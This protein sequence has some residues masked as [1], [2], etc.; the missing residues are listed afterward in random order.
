MTALLFACLLGAAHADILPPAPMG[1]VSED[2]GPPR[3]PPYPFPYLPIGAAVAFLL[4]AGA[5]WRIRNVDPT[6]DA[7]EAAAD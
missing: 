7:E 3:L 5:Y 6:S 2:P 4:A 1:Y